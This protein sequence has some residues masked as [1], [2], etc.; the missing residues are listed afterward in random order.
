MDPEPHGGDG[1]L[2]EE[3]PHLLCFRTATPSIA[4]LADWYLKRAEDIDDYSRQVGP[5][6]GAGLWGGAVEQKTTA[7][8][9]QLGTGSYSGLFRN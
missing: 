9:V 5:G 2:Y 4:L 1:F 3:Q 8:L 7:F 6:R